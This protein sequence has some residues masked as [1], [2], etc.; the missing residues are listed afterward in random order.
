M[1]ERPEREVPRFAL[2]RAEAAASLGMSLDSFERYVQP[3][4]RLIRVGSLRLVPVGEVERWVDD[5][6][7]SVLT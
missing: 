6:A 1:S 2:T 4:V 7:A 5:N 3:H